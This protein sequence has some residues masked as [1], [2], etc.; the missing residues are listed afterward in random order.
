MLDKLTTGRC[1][2]KMF[3]GVVRATRGLVAGLL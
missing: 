1:C 3:G 2:I